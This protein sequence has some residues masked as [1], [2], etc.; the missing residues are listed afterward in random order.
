MKVILL[1][2]IEKVGNKGDVVTVKRGFARNYLVPRNFAL[3]AT[4][5]NLKKLGALKASAA[6]EEEKQLNEL[7][8]LATKIASLKL[9]FTRKV[10]E[11]DHMF[12]SVSETDICNEL[13]SHGVEI[14]KSAVLLDKHIKELGE[15]TVQI[16]LHKD[17]IADLQINVHK[18]GKEEEITDEPLPETEEE[19]VDEPLEEDSASDLDVEQSDPD[20]EL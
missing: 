8:M 7:K 10:D 14:H 13:L 6:Q 3:Y 16:R 18:E 19:T 11:S 12:G 20:D 5:Q 9:D 17:I 4:P 1:S 2:N 15:A